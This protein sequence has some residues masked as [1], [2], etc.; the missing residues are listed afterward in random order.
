MASTPWEIGPTQTKDTTMKNKRQLKT[1]AKC[2]FSTVVTIASFGAVQQVA[3]A[4]TGQLYPDSFPR[5]ETINLQVNNL[6]IN[7][8]SSVIEQCTGEATVDVA[9]QIYPAVSPQQFKFQLRLNRFPNSGYFF[10]QVQ[11]L[12]LPVMDTYIT[13]DDATYL[14]VYQN[15]ENDELNGRDKINGYLVVVPNPLGTASSQN[16]LRTVWPQ[17]VFDKVERA[18]RYDDFGA[19][20]NLRTYVENLKLIKPAGF[21]PIVKFENI[22][23]GVATRFTANAGAYV[24]CV[25]RELRQ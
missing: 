5:G 15:A 7:S 13:T 4:D 11:D 21:G 18:D 20:I 23:S 17:F 8:L 22:N 3:R 2:L 12:K 14:G 6:T 19:P 1:L 9:R 24:D 10:R 25:T 16:N